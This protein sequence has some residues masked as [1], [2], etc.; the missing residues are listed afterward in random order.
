MLFLFSLLSGSAQDPF[1]QNLDQQNLPD[2]SR[3][4]LLNDHAWS[5][6]KSHPGQARTYAE[7]A[8]VRSEAANNYPRGLI[9]A[10]TLLGILSKDQGDY[11]PA[12]QHYLTAQNLAEQSG[13]QLR[14]SG[15]FPSRLRAFQTWRVGF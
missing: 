15:C 2:T 5:L 13:D 11:K 1:L 4:D 8:I 3:I 9:N 14:V 7:T 12:A 10:H 6:A